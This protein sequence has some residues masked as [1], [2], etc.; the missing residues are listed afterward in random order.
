MPISISNIT[1]WSGGEWSQE[2]PKK[3]ADFSTDSRSL[4]PG[5]L[6]IA[7][8]TA[9]RDGHDFLEHA[10]AK[11]ASGAIV[12]HVQSKIKLPQLVVDDP[13]KALQRIACFYRKKWGGIIIAIT[14]SCGK[15]STKELLRLL[16]GKSV[17]FASPKNWNN[18]IGVPLSLL[19]I[20]S[21][22][23]RYAV[24]EVGM[25][26]PGEIE[27][28]AKIINPNTA[29]ITSVGAAHLLGVGSL[30]GV[31]WEKSRLGH[32]MGKEGLVIFPASCLQFDCFQNFPVP[33]LSVKESSPEEV[34]KISSKME[35]V[36]YHIEPI[37]KG[38]NLLLFL[39]GYRQSFFIPS[40]SQG[41]ATNAV[42][43]LTLALRLGMTEKETKEHLLQWQPLP[44]RGEWIEQDYKSFYVDC[45]NANPLSMADSF[46]AFQRGAPANLKRL[47]VLG[48]MDELGDDIDFWH[49]KVALSLKL[50]PED[51]LLFIG[52]KGDAFRRGAIKAG[53]DENQI[54]TFASIE[55]ATFILKKFRGAVL[56]KGSRCHQMERLIDWGKK[57]HVSAQKDTKT[58][59][60]KP[61][62]SC[63]SI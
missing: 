11:G 38:Y 56:L 49:E 39:N 12:S 10:L 29:I 46:T 34:G 52:Q 16:L 18:H 21:A 4:E 60:H 17:T 28:L 27:Q 14:G 57:N 51:A 50:R 63:S 45:Y 1:Q 61:L 24:I 20:D 3:I 13:L 48:E 55:E 36:F 37:E 35:T 58:D 22:Q 23:H 32:S 5:D 62:S 44:L 40:T 8:H 42:L 33:A 30:E 26:Q 2:K 43:A 15:T 7:L 41:M 59:T 9:Q 54:Q 19:A 53:N 6:F 25:N 47:Y 31:A